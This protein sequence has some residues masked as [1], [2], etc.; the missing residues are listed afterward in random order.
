[1]DISS[2]EFE[3]AYDI[4]TIGMTINALSNVGEIDLEHNR[5][6]TSDEALTCFAIKLS[7]SWDTYVRNQEAM[8]NDMYCWDWYIEEEIVKKYGKENR[9]ES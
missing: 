7:N 2:K 4:L 5:E 1:M 3:L 9:H 8:R 6:D